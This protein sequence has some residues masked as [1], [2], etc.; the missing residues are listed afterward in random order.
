MVPYIAEL[1]VKDLALVSELRIELA[2]GL[3]VIEVHVTNPQARES[4]RHVSLIAG[5]AAGVVQGFG[6]SG[7]GL[8]LRGLIERLQNGRPA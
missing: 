4:F 7:Y 8:A 3:T 2:S 5:A 1:S 6:P